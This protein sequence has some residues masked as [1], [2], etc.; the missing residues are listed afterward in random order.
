MGKLIHFVHQSLDG[1]IE[2]PQGEFDW[3]LMGP[4]LSAYSQELTGGDKVFL[5]GRV[6]W[7]MMAGFWP[8]AEQHSTHEH[9]LAFAPVWRAAPKVVVSR[10][11]EKADWNTRVI[12][13]NVVEELTALKKSGVTLLLFGGSGLAAHLTEHGLIDEYRVFVHPVLLGGGKPVFQPQNRRIGLELVESRVLDSQVVL[14]R[15]RRTD[16]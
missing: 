13:E 14:L 12:N 1:F 9:D 15:H 8:Q 4:E 5:Y 6:V 2:G 10:T 3:P 16:G 7:D 11:L